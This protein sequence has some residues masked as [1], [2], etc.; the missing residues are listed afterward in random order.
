MEGLLFLLVP[1]ALFV[2]VGVAIVM[3]VDVTLLGGDRVVEERRRMSRWWRPPYVGGAALLSWARETG[4]ELVGRTLEGN[5]SEAT[6]VEVSAKLHDG[7]MRAMLP[8]VSEYNLRREVPC[9]VGG[10]GTVGVTALEAIELAEYIRNN[11]SAREQASI[12]SSARSYSDVLAD[13]ASGGTSP[14]GCSLQGGDCLCMTY[15]ARPLRCRPLHAAM[16]LERFGLGSWDDG[17]EES[18]AARARLIA[19]GVE[20]GLVGALDIAGLD[21]NLYELNSALATALE[22]PDAARQWLDGEAVFLH[23]RPASS[24]TF[25]A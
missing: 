13:D 22:T 18:D 15:G 2:V 9:P 5:P 8:R 7:A 19:E 25:H 11:L 23:C 20:E 21:G 24:T 14:T 3:L 10:Q 12:L 17:V 4:K 6:P 16:I 1:L